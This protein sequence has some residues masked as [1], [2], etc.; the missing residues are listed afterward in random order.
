MLLDKTLNSDSGL[1]RFSKLF[2]YTTLHMQALYDMLHHSESEDANKT[3]FKD[4]N[5]I[6]AGLL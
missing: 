5:S 1:A 4:L 6:E 2:R 3:A